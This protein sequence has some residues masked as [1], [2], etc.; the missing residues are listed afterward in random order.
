MVRARVQTQTQPAAGEERGSLRAEFEVDKSTADGWKPDWK[1][2]RPETGWDPDGTL[3]LV[4]TK[5]FADSTLYRYRARTQSHWVYGG[6]SGDFRSSYSSW[7]Y[8]KVDS[9]APKEPQIISNGPYTECTTNLCEGKGGPGVPGKFTFKP[10][11]ADTDIT[12]YRWRLLTST[13]WKE[14]TGANPTVGITPAL[15]GTQ[16]LTVQAKDVRSRWGFIQEFTFKVAPPDD[17]VG[18]WHFDDDIDGSGATKAVDTAT[19][20]GSRHDATLH[21]AGAGWSV[22]GRRGEQDQ[23]LWLNDTSDTTRQAGYAATSTPALNTRESFTISAWAYLTDASENRTVLSEPGARGSA[24]TLYYSSAGKRWIFNRTDQ[25]KDGPVY[26]RSQADAQN[27]PLRVWTHLAGVFDTQGDTDKA[28]DTIQLFVNGRPQGAPVVASRQ[29]STYEPWTAT[30]GLQIGRAKG[31]GLYADHFRGRIDEVQIW[32]RVLTDKQLRDDAAALQDNV[33][34]AELVA[35][36]DATAATADTI[37]ERSS[38]PVGALNLSISGARVDGDDNALL[39]DGTAGYA[40]T[41]GPVVDETGSFTVTARVRLDSALLAGKPD[42]YTAQVVGQRTGGESSWA[43]AYR[44]V[45]GSVGVWEFTRTDLDSTGKP[46]KTAR[47]AAQEPAALDT[48]VQVTG[49][50]DAS[51]PAASGDE[52]L[53]GKLHLVVE[54]DLQDDTEEAGFAAAEQGTGELSVGRGTTGGAV[55]RYLPGALEEVRIWAGATAPDRI[56]EQVLGTG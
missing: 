43:L 18:R 5:S 15:S 44:K 10:N 42:G 34:S 55:G 54:H 6:K 41:T 20:P 50:Y 9:T 39:L 56:P 51:E 32:Q 2:H 37:P 17:A 38:Y 46:V 1:N 23:S 31:G 52:E 33:P 48:W 29:A 47:V 35:F 16:V 3:E 24:F 36:W 4:R 27:P 22:M 13:A 11:P 21:T 53:P 25:D 45:A 49:V 7:C 14:V 19:G 26:I 28:N 8:F 40:A 30:E 12:G